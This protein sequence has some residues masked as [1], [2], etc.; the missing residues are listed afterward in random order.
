ML[1]L[2]F[3]FVSGLRSS[4]MLARFSIFTPFPAC[5]YLFLLV[6]RKRRLGLTTIGIDGSDRYCCDSDML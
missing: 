6:T 2:L 4:F 3:L 5:L 1:Y